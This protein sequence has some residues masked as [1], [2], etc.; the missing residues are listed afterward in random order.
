MAEEVRAQAEIYSGFVENLGL[1]VVCIGT[2]GR[3][4]ELRAVRVLPTS[5]IL[6]RVK[7]NHSSS[8][9]SQNLRPEGFSRR[10][11]KWQPT[12]LRNS[13]RGI[14]HLFGIRVFEQQDATTRQVKRQTGT[15][16]RALAA[17]T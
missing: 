13:W 9:A 3:G 1:G 7:R 15:R 17:A 10:L 14:M 5:R 11:E 6:R 4:N 8:E 16:L 12:C 2:S